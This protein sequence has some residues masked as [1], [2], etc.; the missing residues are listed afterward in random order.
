MA[1]E[2]RLRRRVLGASI[3]E[4]MKKAQDEKADRF[5]R[6]MVPGKHSAEDTV[7]YVHLIL[8]HHGKAPGKEYVE[9]RKRRFAML[10][11]YCLDMLKSNTS[12][13]K[14]LP[15]MPARVAGIHVLK[16]MQHQRRGWR[17]QAR[18]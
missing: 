15:V 13:A 3:A 8:A 16:A 11:G 9:Y 7:G 4:A 18:P 10:Q 14:F 5:A 1:L 2:P 17:G 6:N 12:G